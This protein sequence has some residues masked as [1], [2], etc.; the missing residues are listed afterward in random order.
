MRRHAFVLDMSWKHFEHQFYE[1]MRASVSRTRAPSSALRAL[2]RILNEQHNS[3]FIGTDCW[4]TALNIRLLSIE[5]KLANC[6]YTA[7]ADCWFYVYRAC[8]NRV[9]Y[10][11]EATGDWKKFP[12]IRRVYL[13][14]S[15]LAGFS[16]SRHG[17]YF[18]IKQLFVFI[19]LLIL[20]SCKWTK[21]TLAR[22]RFR[23]WN[24]HIDS[25]PS[26]WISFFFLVFSLDFS[27]CS[28]P[29]KYFTYARVELS[30]SPS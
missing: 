13:L 25:L 26:N 19:S 30:H 10:L 23:I 20:P 9:K 18:F 5:A 14:F 6:K 12:T 24:N 8:A 7:K 17:Y 21:T 4:V 16:L 11:A 2:A 22:L 1:A 28:L 29:F 15:Q 27:F 3:V